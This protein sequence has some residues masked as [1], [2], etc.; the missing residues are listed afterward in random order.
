MSCARTQ[1]L[2]IA[3]AVLILTATSFAAIIQ[4]VAGTLLSTD[5]YHG[6][7]DYFQTNYTGT[8]WPAYIDNLYFSTQEGAYYWIDNSLDGGT[9][10]L[11]PSSLVADQT[12]PS[13]LAKGILASGAT[14]TINGD[15]YADDWTTIVAT[16]DLVTAKVTTQWEVKE[17]PAPA[18]ANTVVGRAFF[19]ITGGAL[20][21]ASLNDDGL[22]M[23]DFYLDFTFQGCSPTVT[24][25]STL[26][27]NNAYNCPH[28]S[29]QGAGVPEPASIAILALGGLALIRKRR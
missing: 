19:H 14:L 27:G 28:L 18:V 29:I 25:F 13:G 2:V 15:L 8:G 16:G 11:G 6:N 10:T 24:D 17:L 26:L 9:F 5:W 21:N 3:F 12:P 7:G 4:D 23:G 22:V 1:G 20:S